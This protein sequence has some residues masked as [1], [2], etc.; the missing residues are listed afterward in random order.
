M[1]LDSNKTASDKTG[2]IQYK[3]GTP[4]GPN[5]TMIAGHVLSLKGTIVTNNTKHFKKYQI[6]KWKIGRYNI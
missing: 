2:T 1:S 3:K 5:D 6:L 4:I